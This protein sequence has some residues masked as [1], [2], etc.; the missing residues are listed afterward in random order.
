MLLRPRRVDIKGRTV[1]GIHPL[2]RPLLEVV[3][4][5]AATLTELRLDDNL[6]PY[7][8][9]NL[10]EATPALKLLETAAFI[11]QDT[12]LARAMLRNEPPYT[13]LRLRR[14]WLVRLLNVPLDE[15]GEF[16][17]DLRCH[18]SLEEL[19]I[20]DAARNTSMSSVVDACIAIRLRSL[21]VAGCC[22]EAAG[23]PELTRLVAAGS[24]RSLTVGIFGAEMFDEAHE[25]FTR[26]FVAAVQ[27][28][29]MT[30]L[31]F[32]GYEAGRGVLPGNV[33]EAA[34]FINAR[35][36]MSFQR[37]VNHGHASRDVV[38]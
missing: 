11:D 1:E 19:F 15:V 29:A 20:C 31:V 35:A 17:S 36:A 23:L 18:V 25:N 8:L 9:R 3:A 13:A 14:L 2:A 28:S 38:R 34:A 6:S 7:E 21:H 24:L 37:G 27:A 4:A 5:N 10:L 22:I 12:T 32:F 16:C 26:L 30:K 33:V